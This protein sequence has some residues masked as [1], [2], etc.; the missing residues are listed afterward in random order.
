MIEYNLDK[1][2]L[3]RYSRHGI[4]FLSLD[5]LTY[6][7]IELVVPDALE[8]IKN[9]WMS[10][11]KLMISSPNFSNIPNRRLVTKDG[12][13]VH[14]VRI[15]PSKYDID[16]Q[17]RPEYQLAQG[18]QF[19]HGIIET[20]QEFLDLYNGECIIFRRKIGAFEGVYTAIAS[21]YKN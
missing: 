7:G 11:N 16:F 5:N 6:E 8:N 20:N 1:K 14:S 12:K 19:P 4:T 2:G 21:I 13:L 9:I 17:K 18:S 3:E 10:H 15:I